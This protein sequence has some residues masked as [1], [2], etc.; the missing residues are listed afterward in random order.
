MVMRKKKVVAIDA[1]A[2]IEKHQEIM[3]PTVGVRSLKEIK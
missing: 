3:M 1:A 2:E